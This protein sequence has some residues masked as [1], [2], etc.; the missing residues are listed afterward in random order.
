MAASVVV[1]VQHYEN[2]CDY[3]KQYGVHL[4]P[5][6]LVGS[7]TSKEK[8]DAYEKIASGEANLIIGTHALIQSK[9][10]YKSLDLVDTEEQHR[11]GVNQR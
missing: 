1:A 9:V 8:K 5:V 6:L 7:M 3:I 4:K 11:F 10:K 2:V